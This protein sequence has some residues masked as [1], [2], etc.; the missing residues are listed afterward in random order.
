MIID[1]HTVRTSNQ[2][3]LNAADL[4]T[5]VY[6]SPNPT[7]TK[8]G[9]EQL[10]E[11]YTNLQA[12]FNVKAIWIQVT[13]PVKWEPT[14]AKNIQFISSIIQAAKAYG[15]AVGIYTSAYDWQQITNDWLGPTDTLLWYWS[16]LGPGPMA[17][18]SNNFEDYHPFGP[19]KTPA[20]KQFGQQE[21][22]CGQTVNRDVFTPTVLAARS[23]FTASDGKIQI[24]GYV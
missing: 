5:E 6:M 11:L 16:V 10:Q 14:V 19:W 4:G 17:E 18:T 2:S 8:T 23:A 22:I 21:P 3:V 13:S 24:G 1:L 7:S 12:N 15:L 20:V 9:P